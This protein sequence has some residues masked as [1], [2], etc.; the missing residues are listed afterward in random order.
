MKKLRNFYLIIGLVALAF[1][2]L[3]K[4]VPGVT[5]TDFVYGFCLGLGI[6]ALLAGIITAFIPRFCHKKEE[7]TEEESPSPSDSDA[8]I[9]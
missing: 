9:Q 2:L 8:L 1:A 6:T 5:M 3:A 7:R 4:L